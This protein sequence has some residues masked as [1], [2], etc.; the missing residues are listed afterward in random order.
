MNPL[1][2]C[3]MVTAAHVVHAGPVLLHLLVQVLL[4]EHLTGCHRVSRVNI[5]VCVCV[6][7]CVPACVHV[8][9]CVCVCGP[10]C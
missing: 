7:V 5:C 4:Q 6:C 2:L 3:W 9:V 10:P 1:M 8:C